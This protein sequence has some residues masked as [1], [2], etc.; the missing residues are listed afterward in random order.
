M[1][2]DLNESDFSVKINDQR[3][4]LDFKANRNIHLCTLVNSLVVVVSFAD[5]INVDSICITDI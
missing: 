4:R 3:K 5:T 1:K 2:S